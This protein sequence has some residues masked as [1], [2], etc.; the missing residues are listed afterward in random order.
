MNIKTPFGN[1]YFFLK[2]DE[3]GKEREHDQDQYLPSVFVYSYQELNF[4]GAVKIEPVIRV[5]RV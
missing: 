2:S 5:M 3:R 4:Y 1:A